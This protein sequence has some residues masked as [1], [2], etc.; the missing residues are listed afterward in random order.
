MGSPMHRFT[1]RL[2]A[3]LRHRALGQSL[4]EFAIVLPIL[5]FL[6]LTALDFGRVYLGFVNLQNMARIAANYAA[7]NPDAW[8]GLGDPVV[9]TKYQN[10]ILADAAATNCNLPLV[11][12]VKTAPA[13]T[14]TDFDGDG[15]PEIGDT[16]S[17]SL[18]CQ[19][20]VIT[21]VIS[22]V[23]G[24]SI[25]VSAASVFPVKTGMTATGPGDT[26]GPPP[27][28]AFTGNA[29]I[30]PTPVYGTAPFTVVFRDTSGGNPRSWKWDLDGD[31]VTDSTMEDPPN[32]IYQPGTWIVKLEVTNRY[33]TTYAFQSI[34]V[35]APT[36]VAFTANRTLGTAPL[37]VTF[38]DTSTPA[39]TLSSWQFGTSEGTGAG[40]SVNHT[41]NTAG[42]YTVTLTVTYPT[43]PEVLTKVS[44]IHIDTPTC[45]VPP[46][47]GVKRNEAQAKWISS[48]WGFSG[49]VMDGPYAPSGNYTIT[50][51]SLTALSYV[52]CTS[53]IFVNRP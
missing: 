48:P 30:S 44:Y 2:R 4:V 50:T 8:S 49:L 36:T 51:Q 13:P 24:Q 31:G 25:K 27:S 28:A 15:V 18:S 42:D 33:G 3:H 22:N 38:T 17:V 26:T 40:T 20:A 35:V 16:A 5:L 34:V 11:A 21:P 43:G 7:N 23:V 14:F 47:A 10:Q 41:Y 6:T 46:L 37:T 29:I 45:Q 19:F 39:G 53:N 52:P 32:Q 1:D 9:Q 12:G